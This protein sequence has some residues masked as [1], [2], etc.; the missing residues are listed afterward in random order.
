[1]IIRLLIFLFLISSC[2]FYRKSSLKKSI[3]EKSI[4]EEV[5]FFVGDINND[6]I[7]DTAFISLKRNIETY[8]IEN[9]EKECYINIKFSRNI[10]DINI[11]RSLGVF[12]TKTDDLNKDNSNEILIFS[13]TRE[14]WWNY[15]FL[16]S[17]D[18][19]SWIELAKT[20]GFVRENKD[21]ENRIIKEN[22]EFF[23]IG[24]DQWNEDENGQF[25]KTKIK[26]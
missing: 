22:D 20:R 17:F 7:N 26:I 19:K 16:Y 15:I 21:F 14:G 4:S 18:G 23:L 3:D 12:I 5:K 9:I 1:M 2:K 10:P 13:R 8:E 25:L 11:D 24:D 6:K